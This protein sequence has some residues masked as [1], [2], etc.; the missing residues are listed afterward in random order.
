ME[1]K[2]NNK[3]ICISQGPFTRQKP[4]QKFEQEKT[5]FLTSKDVVS[6]V[7]SDS[8]CRMATP[9]RAEGKPNDE[10]TQKLKVGCKAEIQTSEYMVGPPL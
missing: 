10:G 4:H 5:D 2:L 9:S 3:V 7:Q 6:K 8:S 1:K